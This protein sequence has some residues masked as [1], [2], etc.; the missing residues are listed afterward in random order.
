[1]IK[2]NETKINKSSRD[3]SFK[4]ETYLTVNGQTFNIATSK[5]Y[6]G[7]LVSTAQPCEIQGDNSVLYRDMLTGTIQLISKKIRCTEKAVSAQHYEALEVFASTVEIQKPAKVLK[8]EIGTIIFLDGYSKTKNS[9]E[10]NHI[11]YEI[12][13]TGNSYKCIELTTL[14]ISTRDHVRPF[15]A[16]FGIGLYFEEGFK[17]DGDEND[18]N[19]LV[20]DAMQKK[21]KDKLSREADKVL[22]NAERSAKIEIGK[23]LVN[24]PAGTVAVLIAE[25]MQD[26]SDAMTDYFHSSAKETHIIGFSKHKRNLFNEMREACKNHPLE[27]VNQFSIAPTLDSTG[28]SKEDYLSHAVELYGTKAKAM[29]YWYPSDVHK[30]N[31]SMGKGNYLKKESG[32]TGWEISKERYWDLTAESRKEDIY[33]AAAEGRYFAEPAKA[34][35]AKAEP[36]KAEP[37][38]AEPAKAEPAKAGIEI[39]DYSEKAFAIIGDT[40]PVKD[41]LKKL[42]GRFNFR[43][44]CGPGWIFP[45]TKLDQVKNSL[46]L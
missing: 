32:R 12:E 33:I 4:G 24:I 14:E 43:L 22:L 17:F 35:P 30:E 39:I 46:G 19:N 44:K 23:K 28:E 36:A 16:K 27:A 38:K 15:S 7:K 42:G 10:N 40:K 13:S 21:N 1:M 11:V 45:K 34:E 41:H 3:S 26:H 6:G 8:P 20:I 9:T 25:N 29:Q 31:Y 2:L 37:A 5:R 18:L